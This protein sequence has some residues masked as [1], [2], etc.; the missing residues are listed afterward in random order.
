MTELPKFRR[1]LRKGRKPSFEV[2][3]KCGSYG[4]PHRFGGGRCDGSALVEFFW[5]SGVCGDCRFRGYDDWGRQPSCQV[6]EGREPAAR[7]ERLQEFLLAND[8]HS[9]KL[10]RV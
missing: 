5:E 2:T 7:C 8:A 3:C 4:F 1:R 9:K 6:L 10:P